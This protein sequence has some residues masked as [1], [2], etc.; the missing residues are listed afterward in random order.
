[1]EPGATRS[2]KVSAP[3]EEDPEG[4]VTVMTVVLAEEEEEDDVVEE[5]VEEG[6]VVA[7]AT[8]MEGGSRS[9]VSRWW[10]QYRAN[11]QSSSTT[12]M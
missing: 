6:M 4:V 11:V 8:C 1:M 5:G 12:T 3:V 2:D 9:S 7:G 10:A